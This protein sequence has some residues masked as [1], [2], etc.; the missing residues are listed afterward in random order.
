[1]YRTPKLKIS[2]ALWVV[3]LMSYEEVPAAFP[4]YQ[5]YGGIYR[6][7]HTDEKHSAE[8]LRTLSLETIGLWKLKYGLGNKKQPIIRSLKNRL[9]L[10]PSWKMI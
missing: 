4:F 9:S 6:S 8:P 10:A 3:Q 1:M 7:L 2:L 5:L